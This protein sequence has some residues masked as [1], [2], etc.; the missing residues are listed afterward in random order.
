MWTDLEYSFKFQ[1]FKVFE[2]ETSSENRSDWIKSIKKL[3]LLIG[4][5]T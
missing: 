3:M 4:K 2:T 1:A 5:I